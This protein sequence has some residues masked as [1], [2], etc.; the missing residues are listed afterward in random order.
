MQPSKTG[1]LYVFDRVTG[2][3]VWPIEE[4]PVPLSVVPGEQ[5]S[6]TQPFPTK[7]LPFAH[8]GVT[9]ADVIDFTPKLQARA[10]HVASTFTLGPIFTFPSLVS[11][12]SD[13]NQGRIGTA[14]TLCSQ[15]RSRF[16]TRS[17]RDSISPS[18]GLSP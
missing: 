7:P 3:P 18:R 8:H 17:G 10:R 2:E 6:P 13:G 5:T 9:Q 1:F 11:D 16:G 14:A 4:R 15:C 12:E